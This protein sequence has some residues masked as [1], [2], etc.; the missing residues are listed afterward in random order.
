M[1]SLNKVQLIGRVG[2]KPELVLN[3]KL[4]VSTVNFSLAT[5]E[6]WKDGHGVKKERTIWHRLTAYR[7]DADFANK[8]I[9][10]GDLVYIEGKLNSRS[11]QDN[12][13]ETQYIT[14]IIIS[15]ILPLG[16]KSDNQNANSS[17]E[18]DEIDE[19]DDIPF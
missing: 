11:Y 13:N 14:E 9:K 7:N 4:T 6:K 18:I 5:T 16:R 15:S 19:I 3:E 2:I 8:Y 1:S 17:D 12:K 10:V